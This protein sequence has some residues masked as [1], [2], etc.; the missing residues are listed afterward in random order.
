LP[1][2]GPDAIARIDGRLIADSTGAQI[3]APRLVSSTAAANFWQIAS[4]PARPPRLAPAPDPALVMKKLVFGA[5]CEDA[6]VG[7]SRTSDDTGR[8]PN[9]HF[10]PHI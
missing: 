4:A 9:L 3:C 10:L 8:N 6:V 5:F 2:T 7:T 1:R